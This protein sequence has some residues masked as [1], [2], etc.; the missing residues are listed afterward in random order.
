[1]RHSNGRIDPGAII[2]ELDVNK[3]EKSSHENGHNAL[4]KTFS[5]VKGWKQMNKSKANSSL[6]VETRE[7][8]GRE[9]PSRASSRPY[10]TLPPASRLA[11]IICCLDRGGQREPC[12]S[13]PQT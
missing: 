10:H 8:L 1:M 4:L 2:F 3:W 11:S 6:T 12:T 9:V 13:V 5:A 7:Q